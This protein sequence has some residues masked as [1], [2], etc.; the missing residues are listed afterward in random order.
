MPSFCAPVARCCPRSLGIDG[1]V[2]ADG[3]W[4][5]IAFVITSA[6]GQLYVDGNLANSA[7]WT[8]TA[9]PV[10]GTEPLQIGRYYNYPNTF[11]GDIDEATLWNRA[12]SASE[13]NYLK[14]RSLAG[15]EDGLLGNW[16]FDEGSGT[17]ANNTATN[18]FQGSLSNSPAWVVSQA[19]IALQPIATNCLKFD[20]VNGYVQVAHNPDLDGYPFT[21][22]AWFR[23]TNTLNAFQGIV[24]KYVNSSGNGWCIMM[25]NGLLRAFYY[26]QVT[27]R[28]IDFTYA[29]PITDGAWH[30]TAMTVDA[31]GGKL[32]LDGVLVGSGSWLAPPGGTTGTDPLLIGRFDTV[33]ARFQGVIDEVSVWNRALTAGEIQT[34][35]NLPL[36]GNEPN[37]IAYWRLDEG[38]NTT[39]A[40]S[41]G[42]GHTGTLT[43]RDL[44]AG[45]RNLWHHQW[46]V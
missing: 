17:T 35:R 2:I 4:H 25:Q 19:A 27:N 18:A 44:G 7:N 21:A 34:N 24:S 30:H 39:A 45:H 1:G 38:V 16:R 29:T 43:A 26:R 12:L 6:T 14:H 20:G 13:L 33:A 5:H 9:G 23:T 36:V 10:T 15:R 8:G 32:W 40:D 31:S 22:T 46:P 41:T 37:L 3:N 42:L 11:Q 28:A